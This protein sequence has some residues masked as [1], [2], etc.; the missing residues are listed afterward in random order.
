M[1]YCNALDFKQNADLGGMLKFFGLIPARG[2]SKGIPRKNLVDFG[3]RPLIAS[4]LEAGLRS[5]FLDSVDVS[6]DDD[7]IFET[8]LEHGLKHSRRRPAELAQDDSTA[9]DVV[10]DFFK[11]KADGIA[12]DDFL[13]YLQ[14]TSPLRNSSHI[15]DAIEHLKSTQALSLV[16]VHQVSESPYE[17]I[18]GSSEDW[19]FVRTPPEG[20][21]NRQDYKEKF[22]FINGAIYIVQVGEFKKYQKFINRDSTA[23]WEMPAKY[24]V[25]IDSPQDLEY[26]R[27][28]FEK[29]K[30]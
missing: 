8:V 9:V 4:T 24:G 21:H 5:D 20:A 29:E 16:S 14:P 18:V 22:Y 28:L 11:W 26:A 27:W 12:D 30:I 25:D 23:I 10:L 17:S 19:D 1:R 13:V 15:D 7:E 2:G 6:T 3:G